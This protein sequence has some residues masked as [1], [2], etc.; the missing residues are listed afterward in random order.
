LQT[1]INAI[2]VHYASAGLEERILAAVTSAAGRGEAVGRDLLAAFDEFHIGGRRATRELGRLCGLRAGWRVLDAGC[3]VGG[4]A[5][6]LTAEFG[7]RVA[8]FDLCGEYCRSAR[9]LTDL[10]GLS[11]KV[12]FCRADALELPFRNGCFDAVFSQHVTMNIARKGR[13][14][15]G[16]RRVLRPGGRLALY[17]V[18]AGPGGA[19]RYP[20]P[21]ADDEAISFL[22]TPERLRAQVVEAGF[23]ETAWQ[24]ISPTALSWLRESVARHRERKKTAPRLSP[25]LLLGERA[26]EKGA[27]VSR[28]LQEQRIRVI[29]AILRRPSI[30]A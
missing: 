19:P 25:R 10:A 15:R 17:E 9:R 21:W 2:T 12:A 20:L 13:L 11:G 3:G 30:S 6:T 24:D 14:L 28:N 29:R 1:D 18:C 7:C 4:P 5:R 16:Y 26:A 27:N 8:A 22:V 23:E